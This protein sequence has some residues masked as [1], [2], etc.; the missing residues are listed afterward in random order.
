MKHHDQSHWGKKEFISVIFQH[1]HFHLKKSEQENRNSS[2]IATWIQRFRQKPWRGTAYWIV[3]SWL[4]SACFL[5][6]HRV[7]RPWIAYCLSLGFIAVKR[8]LCHDNTYEEIHL[9]QTCL[10]L[11]PA[12]SW[13]EAW[14]HAQDMAQEEPRV[15]LYLDLK[16]SERNWATP[17][18]LEHT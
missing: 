16:V 9:I 7:A 5:T 13:H 17:V 1:Y 11:T 3:C 10:Q 12:S 4:A 14:Q 2:R 18:Y 6:E 8:H 15:L